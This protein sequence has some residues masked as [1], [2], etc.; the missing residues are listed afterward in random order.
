VSFVC[1]LVL[2]Q[3]VVQDVFLV[4]GVEVGERHKVIFLAAVVLAA[5]WLKAVA[6]IFDAG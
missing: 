4:F 2:F 3:F 5:L 6:A 1:S